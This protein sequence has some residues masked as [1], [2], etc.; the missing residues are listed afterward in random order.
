MSDHFEEARRRAQLQKQEN[1]QSN[2]ERELRKA[3]DENK[4]R[5][6]Q[7][8]TKN[9]QLGGKMAD[10]NKLEKPTQEQ[11]DQFFKDSQAMK[12]NAADIQKYKQELPNRQQA[13]KDFQIQ[14]QAKTQGAKITNAGAEKQHDRHAV[15][16]TPTGTSKGDL[17]REYHKAQPN[18][19]QPK[20]MEMSNS[21]EVNNTNYQNQSNKPAAKGSE[22]FKTAQQQAKENES[23]PKQQ[24]QTNQNQNNNDNER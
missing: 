8:E 6:S 3:I 18:A 15:T 12:T 21:T 22:H 1:Q 23:K 13:L 2:K 17:K 7:L 19:Y 4:A 5:T 9:G 10:F 11:K 16:P 14:Q 20:K 24:Q